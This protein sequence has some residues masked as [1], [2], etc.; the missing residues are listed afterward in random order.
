MSDT[1]EVM[2]STLSNINDWLKFAE[3]KNGALLALNCAL[4]FGVVRTLLGVDSLPNEVKYYGYFVIVQLL[5]SLILSLLSILPR[6][7]PPWWIRFPNKTEN[8]NPLYFG[9]ACKHSPKS[10]LNLILGELSISKHEKI[11]EHLSHQIVINSKIAFIKYSQFN[12]SAWL[13]VSAFLTPIGA[14]I[15]LM[16]KE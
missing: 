3:A 11:H 7:T 15:L 5:G 1:S 6:T 16:V 9:D 10:Y 2:E 14:Y 12:K 8:D 4:V 13:L